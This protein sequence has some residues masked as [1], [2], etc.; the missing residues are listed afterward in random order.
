MPQ[1]RMGLH[2]GEALLESGRYVGVAV[3]R[4]QRVSSAAHGGQILLSNSTRELVADELPTAVVLRDLG[5][6]RLKDIER[7][8]RVFQLEARGLQ[9]AFPPIRGAA[10][11]PATGF[12]VG[13]PGRS[14][15]RVLAAVAAALALAAIAA[16]LV[17]TRGAEEVAALGSVDSLTAVDPGS[18]KVTDRYPVGA[19][20]SAV[21]V[22]EG[23]VWVLSSDERTI[24]RVDP[25]SGERQ[26]FG[27]SETPLDLAVGA[28]ALWVGTGSP[29]P[30]AQTAS[31][32][33]TALLRFSP[34]SRTERNRAVLPRTGGFISNRTEQHI[35]VADDFVW[36]INPDTSI[37]KV[38][39]ANGTVVGTR[40]GFPADAIAAAGKEVWAMQAGGVVARLDPR[41]GRS[42]A[43]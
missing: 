8:E 21:A 38:D 2:T 15:A 1:V 32:V 41:R 42:P 9:T 6:Q 35:A 24:S 11:P 43:A 28:G 5:E 31:P 34:G 4:A 30:N 17:L 37:S 20:P 39:R 16:G 36:V 27:T 33:I 18:A 13:L 40:R 22:G 26:P 23:A 7:P 25:D 29:L 14:A 3:H 10:P 12:G 19:T